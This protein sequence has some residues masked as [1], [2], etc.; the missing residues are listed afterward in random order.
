[1][2]R[3]CI[4][5]TTLSFVLCISN[6]MFALLFHWVWG[7]PAVIWAVSG[8]AWGVALREH[9]ILQRLNKDM[10]RDEQVDDK[11]RRPEPPH[12]WDYVCD[13][14]HNLRWPHLYYF[15]HKAAALMPCDKCKAMYQVKGGEVTRLPDDPHG[16]ENAE[17]AQENVQAQ[18]EAGVYQPANLIGTE[19]EGRGFGK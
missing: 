18:L 12:G 8:V 6:V 3:K 11:P 7:I 14:G 17:K 9:K 2:M 15:D 13:C 4:L 16:T 5:M 19:H 10:E 1:M